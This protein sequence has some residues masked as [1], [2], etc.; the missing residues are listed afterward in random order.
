MIEA[1]KTDL[2]E[3]GMGQAADLSSLHAKAFP[4]EE[5]WSQRDIVDLLQ[6]DTTTCFGLRVHDALVSFVIAQVAVDQAEILTIVTSPK[7]Q[8]QGYAR[9]VLD[10]SEPYFQAKGAENWLLDVA[11]DNQGARAF[12]EKLGFA[13]DGRRPQYYKRLEGG[14]VD[15]ILM[16]RPMGGQ[17]TS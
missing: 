13:E 9:Q 2:I 14:R 15:A 17:G 4:R 5:A 3:L 12:Y 6:L 11:E 10:R 16:S 7:H 1:S 8:Q